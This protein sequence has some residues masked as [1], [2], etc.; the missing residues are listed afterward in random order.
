MRKFRGRVIPEN[1]EELCV[2]WQDYFNKNGSY[3]NSLDCQNDNNLPAWSRVRELCGYKFEE[4]CMVFNINK[5]NIKKDYI[6]YCELFINTCEKL[7]RTLTNRDLVNNKYG[8]PSARWLV[9]NCPD[10]KVK[11]YD[12]F[13]NYLGLKSS[14]NVSKE[15]ASKQILTK[16]KLLKRAL[17]QSDFKNPV[18]EEIGMGT[19]NNLWG[20]F[21]NMLEDLNLPINQVGRRT[22]HRDIETL[23]NDIIKVCEY[24]Y[25]T[26]GIKNV[27]IEDISNCDWC[28]DYGTYNRWFKKEYNMT[29]SQFISSIGYIPNKVGVG[30]TF[31]F[32]DG[33]VTKSKYE[34]ETS[35]YLRNKNIPYIRDV[36]YN[37]FTDYIGSKDCDYVITTNNTV[38]Y[39]EIAGMLDY[40]KKSKSYDDEI[41]KRY[42][43]G[44]N[45]KIELLDDNKLKYIILY[46]E[47][48]K[49]KT[50]DEIFAFLLKN[51]YTDNIYRVII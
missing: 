42:K 3:P 34:Y 16:Y 8:I 6:Y 29:V 13:I 17:K 19:I 14:Y 26:K 49:T 5:L 47:D 23:K 43:K 41:R 11:T 28:L 48:F 21:N 25:A 45:K 1:Y 15:Y 39:V 31:E 9:K 46:P 12:D 18:G 33:E 40:T 32:E 35:I 51:I 7:E 4:F 37:T 27:S 24:V 2:M 10:E 22:L 20:S 36:R 38:W 50:L 44:L 30:M